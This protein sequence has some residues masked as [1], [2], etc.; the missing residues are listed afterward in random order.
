MRRKE[1]A[2]FSVNLRPDTGPVQFG[3]DWPGVFFRGDECGEYV[4]A[5]SLACDLLKDHINCTSVAARS[6]QRRAASEAEVRQLQALA[7]LQELTAL[8]KSCR[9]TLP[10]VHALLEERKGAFNGAGSRS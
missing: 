9:L 3:Q 10:Q 2:R 5:I 8:F 4:Q 7:T 1:I 6:D